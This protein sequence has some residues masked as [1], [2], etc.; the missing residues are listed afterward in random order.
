MLKVHE[1][2]LWIKPGGQQLHLNTR[3]ETEE[4][5]RAMGFVPFDKRHERPDINYRV[6]RKSVDDLKEES[7]IWLPPSNK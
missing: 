6:E 1:K 5:A 3:P 2:R 7:Q 4:A